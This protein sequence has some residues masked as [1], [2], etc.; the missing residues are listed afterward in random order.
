M[1]RTVLVLGGYGNFG[2]LICEALVK[3]YDIR[4]QIA[5]RDFK[6]ASL[7]ARRLGGRSEPIEL[8]LQEQDF[9]SQIKRIGPSVL[10]HTS[11]PFQDQSYSVAEGCI[12]AGIH[13]IDIADGRSFV[14]GIADLNELAKANDVMVVSG[15]S[16]LPALSS[17]VIDHYLPEFSQLSAIQHGISSGAKP[18]G[19]ATMK[20]VMSY[21]GKEFERWECGQWKTIHGWQDVNKRIYP[22]PV[23]RR[24][25]ASC[26]V[27]DLEL[28]PSRY[29]GVESV[30]FY[31]GLGF[32]STTWATWGLSWLVRAGLVKDLASYS[33]YLHTMASWLEPLGT[34]WSAMH[35]ELSGLDHEQVQI[36]RT[37]Y[38]LAGQA[39][40]PNIPCFPAVALAR[41]I[42]REEIQVRGAMPCMGLL[43]MDEIL[44][45]MPNLDIR[46]VE[47]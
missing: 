23:G 2:S 26:D 14:V 34:K 7:L 19:I 5:G 18:P 16:S 1:L 42:I 45:A 47:I 12:E 46:T 36:T 11:G 25:L 21:V 13:Y 35:V 32:M 28:F 8:D 10:I 3:D 33:K 27:P 37:W 40:G 6:R 43:N 24:W 9:A 15:A 4:V 22:S 29:E 31:A 44:T 41:K 30:K 20:A 17:A 39:H 38:L